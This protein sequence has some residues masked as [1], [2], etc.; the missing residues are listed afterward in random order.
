M[1]LF[2]VLRRDGF[3]ESRPTPFEKREFHKTF[4]SGPEC[5]CNGKRPEVHVT[6]YMPFGGVDVGVE[7]ESC[8][9]LST[10]EWFS[11]KFYGMS[12]AVFKERIDFYEA[13]LCDMW[14]VAFSDGENGDD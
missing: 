14:A 9:Q 2:D 12:P 3:W 11:Q 6:V 1:D 8:A 7:I 13:M 10:G 4:V 5:L